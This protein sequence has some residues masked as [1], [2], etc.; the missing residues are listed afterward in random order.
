[1]VVTHF[2]A[3]MPLLIMLLFSMI[4]YGKGLVHLLTLAYTM[5]LA[6]VVVSG[7][8]EILFFPILSITGLIAIILFFFAMS[9]GNW[10]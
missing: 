8:W 9:R 2:M 5:T 10:L 6:F 4:F 7:S 3:L 1:M